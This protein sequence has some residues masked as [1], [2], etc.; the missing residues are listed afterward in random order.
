MTGA[1]HTTSREALEIDMAVPPIDITMS[2][3]LLSTV[4]RIRSSPIYWEI[5]RIREVA[6]EK[7]RWKE[8]PYNELSPL[9]QL[10]KHF[11]LTDDSTPLE[12]IRTAVEGPWDVPTIRPTIIKDDKKAI[13]LH[14]SV[15]SA[16]AMEPNH[17]A[18]YADAATFDKH[19]A[20]A[21]V[22]PELKR[23]KS[24]LVGPTSDVDIDAGETI[25][26]ILALYLAIISGKEN[27]SIFSDSRHALEAI[28]RNKVSSGQCL[29]HQFLWALRAARRRNINISLYWIPSHSKIIGHDLADELARK[30]AG[31][32]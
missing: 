10:E 7:R 18:I 1:F 11:S 6:S 24:A 15:V 26:L 30:A 3:Q 29:N 22:I 13:A 17:I 32:H 25:A 20:A 8:I 12:M 19:I 9:Q 14:N 23:E 16:I 27:I 21:A 5:E 4:L 31:R 2:R 28:E